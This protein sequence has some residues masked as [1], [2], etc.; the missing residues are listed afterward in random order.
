M[1]VVYGGG[2]ASC[3]P[4]KSRRL[5]FLELVGVLLRCDLRVAFEPM[6]KVVPPIGGLHVEPG[7]IWEKFLQAV[8][9]CLKVK[10]FS[11]WLED[12]LA[13]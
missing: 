2:V 3:V 4:V 11:V 6:K 7:V 8:L 1:L 9:H 13:I 12:A 5:G 10:L